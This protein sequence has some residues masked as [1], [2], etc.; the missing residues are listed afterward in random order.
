MSRYLSLVSLNGPRHD[1]RLKYVLFLCIKWFTCA[2]WMIDQNVKVT[3]G[4]QGLSEI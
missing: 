2:V 3:C 1:Q 4:S